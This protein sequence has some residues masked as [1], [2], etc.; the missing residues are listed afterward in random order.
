M[1]ARRNIAITSKTEPGRAIYLYSH[2]GGPD[3]HVV[4]QHALKRGQDRW[5][6]PPYLTRIIFSEMIK[7]EVLQNTGYGISLEPWDEQYPTIIVDTKSKTV[8][9]VPFRQYVAMEDNVLRAL[10]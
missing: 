4:L 3:M 8:N 10:E 7:D 1:G 2:W 6:D 5:D 9:G